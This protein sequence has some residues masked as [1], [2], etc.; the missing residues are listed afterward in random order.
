[1]TDRLLTTKEAARLIGY[2]YRTL[3]DFRYRGGGPDFIELKSGRK[4]YSERVVMDWARSGGQSGG[5]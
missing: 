1:M 2:S 5:G 4:R 3:E